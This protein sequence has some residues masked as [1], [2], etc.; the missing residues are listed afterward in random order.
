M[1]GIA[2]PPDARPADPEQLAREL[3]DEYGPPIDEWAV[4]ALLE[5]RGV[6]DRD[7]VERYGEPDVFALA[8]RVYAG[9]VSEAAPARRP[10]PEPDEREHPGPVRLLFRGAYSFVPLGVQLAAL[11][12]LGYST[13]AA[14]DFTNAQA[15]IVALAVGCSYVL[16]APASQAIGYLGPYFDEPGK[17]ILT[18]RVSWGVVA[19]GIVSGALFAALAVG[20]NAV[21]SG[22]F[23]GWAVRVWLVYYALMVATWSV[24]AVLYFLHRYLLMLTAGLVGLGVMTIVRYGTDASIYVQQWSGL[25]ANLV[26]LTASVAVILTLR[27]RE[28][29]GDMR[30]AHLPPVRPLLRRVA[31]YAAFGGC[32]FTFLFADRIVAWSQGDNPFPIWFHVPYEIGLDL[33]LV[34][35]IGAMAFLEVTV[36]GFS[37]LIETVPEEV[38]ARAP[39]EHNRSA[40]SF[41]W[42]RLGVVVALCAIGT[43]LAYG[44]I[45]LVRE[46]DPS[47]GVLEVTDDPVVRWVFAWAAAGYALLAIGLANSVFLFA[48]VRPWFVVGAAAAAVVV[49]VPVAIWLAGAHDYWWAVIGLTAGAGTFAVLTGIFAARTL[50]RADLYLYEAY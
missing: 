22:G 26:V 24:T 7:A 25:T 20:V 32:Y 39:A 50:R 43:A 17:H 23:P 1:T 19:F 42:R 28:T 30:L 35:I 37:G 33:G 5:S 15:T 18:R 21:V 11:F 45:L 46:I 3:L 6:R 4:A 9:M 8:R 16:T 13:I 14:L 41:W 44:G 27:A 29:R 49:D 48:L 2:P 36:H 38:S 40:T 34:A 12:I 47:H 31:P 10:P